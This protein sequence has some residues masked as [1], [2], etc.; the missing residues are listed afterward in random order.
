MDTI[1][2]LNNATLI[3]HGVI[4]SIVFPGLCFA[5]HKLCSQVKP[6]QIAPVYV[7]NL[8][9]SDLIQILVNPIWT[10][11][12]VEIQSCDI[13]TYMRLIY[14]FSLQ[15]NVFF[16]VTISADRYIMIA[17][18]FWYENIQNVR[19][20]LLVSASVWISVA[21]LTLASI[22]RTDL[23]PWFMIIL[24]V[25]PYPLVIFCFV[26]T[27]RS[28]SKTTLS[29][30]EQRRV[31]GVLALVLCVYTVLFL[32]FERFFVINI[33]GL[34]SNCTG[35]FIYQKTSIEILTALNP[36][37]DLVLY[38]FMRRDIKDILTNVCS[39]FC[40]RRKVSPVDI[41]VTEASSLS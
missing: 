40:R 19:T 5:V 24:L 30:S 32:P 34:Q 12:R 11:L 35:G 4:M 38:V 33:A 36:L 13:V 31:I 3:V 2:Y 25:L 41:T 8:L 28:L 39:C 20:S 15:V 23:E 18:A 1:L 14:V 9:I 16:M 29:P 21:A 26:G 7:I 10:A 17:H 22:L 37:F 6:D 27:W